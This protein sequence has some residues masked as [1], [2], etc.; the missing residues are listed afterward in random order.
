MYYI[1]LS[2][3]ENDMRNYLIESGFVDG[4]NEREYVYG[5]WTIRLYDDLIEVYDGVEEGQSG[6]Y[7]VGE[8]TWENLIIIVEEV[9][10]KIG[11]EG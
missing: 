11:I 1:C 4:E 9:L 5:S 2:K 3:N 6:A 8:N 10:D 7:W